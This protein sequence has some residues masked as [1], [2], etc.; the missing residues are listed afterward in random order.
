[1]TF[2]FISRAP[3]A[4]LHAR[5]HVRGDQRTHQ[6]MNGSVFAFDTISHPGRREWL[7]IAFGA[8]LTLLFLPMVVWKVVGLG[9]GDVQVFFRAG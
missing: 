5:L 2:H 6:P 3:K 4:R 9:Q 8:A 1:M 7:V